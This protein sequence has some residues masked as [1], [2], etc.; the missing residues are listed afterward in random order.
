ML[1]S[2][3]QESDSGIYMC[4]CVC[5]CV[6]VCMCLAGGH[7]LV[8]GSGFGLKL[9]P[10]PLG[11]NPL[12]CFPSPYHDRKSSGNWSQIILFPKVN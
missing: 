5:V 11:C 3:I 2:S 4:V 8:L 6:C 12:K 9:V 10:L 1:V 7:I